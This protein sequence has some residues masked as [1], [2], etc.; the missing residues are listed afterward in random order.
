MLLAIPSSQWWH[1]VARVGPVVDRYLPGIEADVYYISNFA[2]AGERRGKGL[3]KMLLAHVFAQARKKG[4]KRCQLDVAEKQI[5]ARSFYKRE[6]MVELFA[7][8]HRD[9]RERFDLPN[10]VRMSIAL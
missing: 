7:T 9:L 1:L 2:I 10:L 4:F 6:G 8:D 3:G 5:R